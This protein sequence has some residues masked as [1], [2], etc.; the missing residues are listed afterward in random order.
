VT[1]SDHSN[2]IRVLADFAVWLEPK[3][4]AHTD[5]GYYLQLARHFIESGGVHSLVDVPPE[6]LATCD[7]CGQR[8][9]PEGNPKPEHL[10]GNHYRWCPTC[11]HHQLRVCNMIGAQAYREAWRAQEARE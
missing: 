1:A 2:L 8:Y 10:T 4:S 9:V 3:P 6:A 5:L 11:Y 7:L